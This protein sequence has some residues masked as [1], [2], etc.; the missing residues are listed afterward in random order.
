MKNQRAYQHPDA[1]DIESPKVPVSFRRLTLFLWD[2]ILFV[3]ISYFKE[4][5]S[6]TLGKCCYSHVMVP[7][8]DFPVDILFLWLVQPSSGVCFRA[9]AYNAFYLMKVS[10]ETPPTRINYSETSEVGIFKSA[11]YIYKFNYWL[12]SKPKFTIA[13]SKNFLSL[14]RV[15]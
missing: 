12:S 8:I 3:W 13:I 15:F 11:I 7:Y 9:C 10:G 2:Y 4:I 6:K 14:R 1:I 5:L